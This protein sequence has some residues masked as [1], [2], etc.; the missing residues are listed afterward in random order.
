M[1]GEDKANDKYEEFFNCSVH[2]EHDFNGIEIDKASLDVPLITVD[3]SINEVLCD[4]AN[5]MLG[6][7]VEQSPI[8]S[9][10]QYIIN[11]LPLGVPEID[12][13]AKQLG[14]SV[15]TLQRKLSDN[16]QTFTSM[17]D[18]I[19]KELALS[20]LKNTNTK[21]IYITQ[22]LGFSEQSAFQRAFKRWTGHTPK[23][24][25]LSIE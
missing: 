11:H 12:E 16:E 8:E 14:L 22:M 2:F 18:S 3:N 20:Y 4:Q 25:R 7:I 15:R 9:V 13:A 19:R 5:K 6:D 21:V 23:Q 24:Y 10:N 17:I 1:K